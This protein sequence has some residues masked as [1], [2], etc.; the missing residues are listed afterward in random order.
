MKI[1]VDGGS[2]F[3]GSETIKLL[4]E[5]GHEV[6][7][8]DLMLGY[9]I[10]DESQ[11]Y[12]VCEEF[13]PDRWLHLAAIARFADADKDPK[14]AFETNVLGTKNVVEVCKNYIFLWFIQVVEVPPCHSI[15]TQLHIR[16]K[17]PPRQFSYGCTKALGEYLV[18]EHQPHI[19]LRY[20][21]LF[22]NGKLGSR[23]GIVAGFYDRIKRGL[24]PTL[25]GGDQTN[26]FVYIYDVAKANVLALQQNL[27]TGMK[28]IMWDRSRTYC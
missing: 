25:Y 20:G 28:H 13:K 12:E 1:L 3:V 8:Y 2:G 16:K 4:E 11:L 6:F 23:H 15:I 19:I 21:H 5:K 17:Y 14:L 26:D 18:K 10:R 7:N 24:E 27:I 9:D 22:G